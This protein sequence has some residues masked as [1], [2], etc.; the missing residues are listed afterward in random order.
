MAS[1]RI[2]FIGLGDLGSH[3]FDP[4]VRTSGR[5]S[6]LVGGRNLD[7]LQQRT[8]LSLLS[9]LQLGYEP[10]IACTYLDLEQR[11]QT[12]ETIAAFQPDII[13]C[14]ATL[15]KGHISG[16]SGSCSKAFVVSPTWS[17]TSLASCIDL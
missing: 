2:L 14:A 15:Q 3:M 6:F 16:S 9:A 11:E 13:V 12:A 1:K 4:L 8:N 10:D 5:H 17:S 7:Y